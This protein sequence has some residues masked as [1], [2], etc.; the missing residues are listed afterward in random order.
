MN[1]VLKLFKRILQY[2]ILVIFKNNPPLL[3]YCMK[4]RIFRYRR[5]FGLFNYK[6]S[7]PF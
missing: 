7:A 2:V 3:K 1:G 6:D 5:S 4:Q